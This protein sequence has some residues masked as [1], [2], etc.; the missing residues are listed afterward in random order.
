MSRKILAGT[1]LATLLFSMAATAGQRGNP[2][3]EPVKLVDINSAPMEDIETVVMNELLAK[4]IIDNRPYANKRQL[5]TRK[6]ITFE[7]YEEIKDRI[8]A[9]R[10]PQ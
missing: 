9:K 7:Q 1:I 3:P 6:L 10:G 4:K 8:I 2:M 5:V